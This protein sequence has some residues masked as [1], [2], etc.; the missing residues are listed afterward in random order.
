MSLIVGTFQF[1]CKSE[2]KQLKWNKIMQ[3]ICKSDS[4][5]YDFRN[6]FIDKVYLKNEWQQFLRKNTVY[7]I[8]FKMLKEIEHI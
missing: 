8:S 7:L 6:L 2:L 3:G 1:C 5:L 4:V